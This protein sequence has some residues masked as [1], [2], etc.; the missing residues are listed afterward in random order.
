MINDFKASMIHEFE[1]TDIGLMAYYLGIE[2]K[3][4]HEI[5]AKFGMENSHPINTLIKGGSKLSKYDEGENIDPIY[6]KS[7]VRSLRY[8]TATHPDILYEVDLISR[9]MEE[10][11][12]T[13]LKKAERILRYL[14]GTLEHGLFYPSTNNHSLIGYNDCDWTG[15][16]DDQKS[17]TVRNVLKHLGVEQEQPTEIH[18]DNQLAIALANNLVF[19]E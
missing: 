14:K 19:H 10:P 15:D 4:S 17:T 7:L 9:F 8:L 13:H 3:Q 18:V 5:L 2:V 11:K 16:V 6:F 12:T 1:M